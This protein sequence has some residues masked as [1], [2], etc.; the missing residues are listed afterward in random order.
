MPS[1]DPGS[2]N[3]FLQRMQEMLLIWTQ[4]VLF[5]AHQDFL[6]LSLCGPERITTL[7]CL[8]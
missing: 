6:Q 3:S 1:D 8:P 5:T 2:K 7:S 4:E